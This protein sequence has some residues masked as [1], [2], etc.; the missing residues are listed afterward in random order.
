MRGKRSS[1]LDWS[2]GGNRHFENLHIVDCTASASVS[3]KYPELLAL[4][5]VVTAN[6]LASAGSLEL[7]DQVGGMLFFT[8]CAHLVDLLLL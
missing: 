1:C 3:A 2:H 8:F 6:K 5:V 7:F 4:G